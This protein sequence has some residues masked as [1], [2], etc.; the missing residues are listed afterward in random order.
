MLVLGYG[1]ECDLLKNGNVRIVDGEIEITSEEFVDELNRALQIEVDAVYLIPYVD[2][3]GPAILAK[4]T[5]WGLPEE[6]VCLDVELLKRE[7]TYVL[8]KSG[9]LAALD[10]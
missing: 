5:L 4:Y 8:E 10:I 6:A 3:G 7:R 2:L 1:I 9:S